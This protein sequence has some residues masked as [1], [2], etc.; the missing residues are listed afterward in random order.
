MEMC[1]ICGAKPQCHNTIRKVCYECGEK[2]IQEADEIA[3][4]LIKELNLPQMPM[5]GDFQF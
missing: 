2:L 1:V 4:D 5:P 3:E